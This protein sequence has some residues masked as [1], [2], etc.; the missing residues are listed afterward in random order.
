MDPLKAELT[1]GD[2]S[3]RARSVS[4]K[5]RDSMYI[6]IVYTYMFYVGWIFTASRWDKWCFGEVCFDE[7]FVSGW[8]SKVG[9]SG[10][11]A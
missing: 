2:V 1:S 6:Y 7:D 10:D 8:K 4:Q 9:A 11:W 5:T 3:E